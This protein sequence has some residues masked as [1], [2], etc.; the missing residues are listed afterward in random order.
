MLSTKPGL[1]PTPE[2]V[3]SPDEHWFDAL[4]KLTASEGVSRRE[5][6][7]IGLKAGAMALVSSVPFAR[8]AFAQPEGTFHPFPLAG[9]PSTAGTGC[10][11]RIVGNS[12]I[13]E[14]SVSQGGITFQ[15]GQSYDRV[16]KVATISIVIS[17]G[18]SLIAKIDSTARAGIATA[19]VTSGVV[20]K[21][22]KECTVT[23]HDRKSFKGTIDGRAFTTS[24]L[25]RSMSA[26][27]FADGKPPSQITADQNLVSALR[28]LEKKAAA[29]SASCRT[30][31][32]PRPARPKKAYRERG[33]GG[34]LGDGWYEPGETYDAPACSQ[35]SDNCTSTCIHDC[36]LDTWEVIFTWAAS[37]ACGNLC[38]IG[39]WGTCQFPGGGCCP[40]PCGGLGVCCGRGDN[41]FHG[42]LCCPGKYVVCNNICC[43]PGVSNCAS[44][45]FCGCP[46]LGQIPCGDNCCDATSTCC[47]GTCCP[48][49]STQC[50]GNQCCP[51]N[52]QCLNNATCCAPPSHVCGS[53]C[54]PPFNV[55]CGTTCCGLNQQCINGVCTN[56]APGISCSGGVVA[57]SSRNW[58]GPNTPMCCPPATNCCAGKCCQAGEICCKPVGGH[59]G[60][61]FGCYPSA[62][63][64][65]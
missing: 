18:Q 61:P 34:S 10:I 40:V 62:W 2:N 35:C 29:S 51:T 43:G 63:C 36:G 27:R 13:Q 31:V 58:T 23:T 12:I 39:C 37:I 9:H 24:E 19:T 38:W 46:V 14:V 53:I 52:A 60:Q 44:D 20:F 56:P 28:D 65:E 22:A 26:V 50:C 41:C 48:T 32:S 21:G 64:T 55:C 47:G 54:C 11:R 17:R 33:Q 16:N 5:A 30:L 49:G 3:A 42:D 45:G 8:H 15:R 1:S 4:L 7:V 6:L 59:A 25:P 57:C